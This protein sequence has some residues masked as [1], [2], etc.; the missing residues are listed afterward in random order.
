M[1]NFNSSSVDIDVTK[2]SDN[3]KKKYE[4]GTNP[5]SLKNLKSWQKGQS[6]N[7]GGKPKG[8]R[9][10]KY[11]FFNDLNIHNTKEICNMI[12]E[13]A[14]SGSIPAAKFI[15]EITGDLD[16]KVSEAQVVINNNTLTIP[17]E[18]MNRARE[19]AK[20][21]Y[22]NKDNVID[23][24]SSDIVPKFEIQEIPTK[25]EINRANEF[26]KDNE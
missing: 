18:L 16:N 9:S 24:K 21:E 3:Y 10:L 25:D 26:L 12:I 6:G 19:Y 4:A 20:L 14:K 1:D 11:A 13:M 22:F 7:L 2:F 5:N 8:Y 15:A 17:E 23:V